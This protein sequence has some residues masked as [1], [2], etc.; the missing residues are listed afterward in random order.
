MINVKFEKMIEALIEELRT[1]P[2]ERTLLLTRNM[3]EMISAAK[4]AD[5]VLHQAPYFCRS[6]YEGDSRY[7]F[8][9]SFTVEDGEEPSDLWVAN[10]YDAKPSMMEFFSD[11]HDAVNYV[12]WPDENGLYMVAPY[13]AWKEVWAPWTDADWIGDASPPQP[14]PMF[15]PETVVYAL[16]F[17]VGP[18]VGWTPP[19]RKVSVWEHL[20]N[21][22][23]MKYDGKEVNEM[24]AK[25]KPAAKAA[26]KPK[27]KAPKKAAKTAK[28]PS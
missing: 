28:K 12:A 3:P 6:A 19:G 11:G 20:L 24:P 1:V 8:Q 9:L 10:I 16:R 13:S 15:R 4:H 2:D 5:R 22:T 21:N 18:P 17:E 14:Q 23:R 7:F 26:A 25:K 27:V